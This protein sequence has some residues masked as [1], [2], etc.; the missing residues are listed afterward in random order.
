MPARH[1]LLPVPLSVSPHCSDLA[2]HACE[3]SV[4]AHPPSLSKAAFAPPWVRVQVNCSGRFPFTLSLEGKRAL[5]NFALSLLESALAK[6]APVT[7]LGSALTNPLNLK[8]F[9]IRTYEKRRGRGGIVN[10]PPSTNGVA[11]SREWP[12]LKLDLSN[13]D[14]N[15]WSQSPIFG[16]ATTKKKGSSLRSCPFPA[17]RSG[18]RLSY[19]RD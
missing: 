4:H 2:R 9:R 18:R 6:N 19:G 8:C 1:P 5:C 15:R 17:Y 3:E 10:Q 11:P 12:L 7:L 13:L 14:A 16:W